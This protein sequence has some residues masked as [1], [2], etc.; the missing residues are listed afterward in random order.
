MDL[1]GGLVEKKGTKEE[2]E[3]ENVE[4]LAAGLSDLLGHFS[5]EMQAISGEVMEGSR[6]GTVEELRGRI[7]TLQDEVY[8][9]ALHKYGDLLGAA[10]DAERDLM[11]K[12]TRLRELKERAGILKEVI[13]SMVKPGGGE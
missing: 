4:V 7:R 3:M 1:P 12:I 6:H 9:E 10:V 8:Q 2:G 5:K 11:T 13:T